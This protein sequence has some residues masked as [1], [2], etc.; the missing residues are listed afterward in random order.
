MWLSL[1][2]K[3]Q[4]DVPSLVGAGAGLDNPPVLR[5]PLG[6]KCEKT[7]PKSERSMSPETAETSN[8]RL[9]I[10]DAREQLAKTFGVDPSHVKISI[11][12]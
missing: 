9:S 6:E 8:G 1:Y 10:S 5:V 3:E 4:R 7:N 2:E 12:V 11:E